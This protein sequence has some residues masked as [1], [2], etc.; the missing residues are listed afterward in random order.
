MKACYSCTHEVLA[1]AKPGRSE[2]CPHCGADLRCCLNCR[3][4]DPKAYNGCRETQAERVLDK[5]RGNFC[6]FFSFREC[7]G[8]AAADRSGRDTANPLDALFKK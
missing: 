7:A 2:T 5:D 1:A 4:H 8:A 6:D 3:F